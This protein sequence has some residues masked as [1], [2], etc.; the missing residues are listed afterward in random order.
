MKE[1]YMLVGDL[2]RMEIFIWEGL[3]V[4]ALLQLCEK[5]ICTAVQDQALAWRLGWPFAAT[6]RQ[7]VGSSVT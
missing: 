2:T 1:K 5:T 4:Y 7:T 6:E 3:S